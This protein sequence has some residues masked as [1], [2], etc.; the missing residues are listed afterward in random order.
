MK[1]KRWLE[2]YC[3]CVGKMFIFLCYVIIRRWYISGNRIP[4][5][6]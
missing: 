6:N 1:G 2:F 3:Y 5:G 4:Y